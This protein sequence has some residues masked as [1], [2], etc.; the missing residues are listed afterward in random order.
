M[1]PQSSASAS[2]PGFPALSDYQDMLRRFPDYL[3]RGWRVPDGQPEYFGDPSHGE[4]GM[5]AMGNV[6]FTAALLATD[7]QCADGAAAP[8]QQE[9]LGYARKALRYM[10]QGH[11]TGAGRC[12]DGGQ[13]GGVW[14]SAWWTARM[15]MGARLLWPQ[16]AEDERRDVERVI[17][18][19]ADLQL[20]RI[21]PSGLAED[22]KA[23]ENAWDTEILAAALA[24]FPAHAHATAW[25]EKLIEFAMNTLSVPQDRWD[26]RLVDGRR[27]R[28]QVYTTNLHSDYTLEN[29]GAYH[30]CYVASPLQSIAWTFYALAG[31][32]A[33]LPVPEALFHH[34]ED[35]WRRVKPTFLD[36]RFAYV[37]GKDWARYTYGLYFIVPA[38]VLV[39]S[40]YRDGD[41]RAIESA[42][43]QCLASEQ[44]ENPDG[45]FFGRRFTDPIRY[46]Q[47]AKYE[48][49]CF[50]NLALAYRLHA[51]LRPQLAPTPLSELQRNLGGCHVSPECGVAFARSEHVFAS[52]SWRTLTTPFPIALFIP[53]GADDMAEWQGNNL[54][55]RI[56]ADEPAHSVAIRSMTTSRSGFRVEGIVAYRDHQARPLYDQHLLYDVDPEAREATVRCRFVAKRRIHVRSALGLTLAIANDRFNGFRRVYHAPDGPTEIVFDPDAPNPFGRGKSGLLARIISRLGRQLGLDIQRTAFAGNWINVDDR[57]GIVWCGEAAAPFVLHRAQGRNVPDGSL[58][59]DVLVAPEL[60]LKRRFDAEEEILAVEFRLIAGTADQTREAAISGSALGGDAPVT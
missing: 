29:H 42:R 1:T 48:T 43:V 31:G 41:A 17:V 26:E 20:P 35:L 9:M 2:R 44:A 6:V 60:R 27:I 21:V 25:R 24:L 28:D 57:F 23:E 46:G 19:E 52:F 51:L 22:T 59:Y 11:R 8:V 38:L 12:G 47:P 55:G 36:T 34:V 39:Q 58:H 45:S 10:T 7:P 16:L 50:A 13:W 15:A 18:F 3:R 5:R 56:V 53:I 37:S 54:L 4:A 32:D 14:Q 40:R 49:D 30:F 33:P